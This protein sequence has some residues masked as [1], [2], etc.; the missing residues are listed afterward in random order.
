[1]T[2]SLDKISDQ[3][4]RVI[5]IEILV[6]LLILGV[7]IFIWDMLMRQSAQI[8]TA[9]GIGEKSEVLAVSGS[10]NLPGRVYVSP[11][12]GLS[13]QP[14]SVIKEEGYIIPVDIVPSSKKIKDRH[15]VQML[16]HMRLVET[17]EGKRPPYGTLIMGREQRSVRIKN[18]EEKQ[19]WLDDLLSE[20]HSILDG[21]PAVAKPAYYKCKGCDVRSVCTQTPFRDFRD[22]VPAEAA[23][24]EE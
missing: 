17:I 19:R 2:I 4:D 10:T 12:L 20:M 7:I 22:A 18:T 13:S 21:V 5:P 15:V 24:D 16:V 14:H 6:I 11:E 3:I 9:G 8:K 23:G 1:M